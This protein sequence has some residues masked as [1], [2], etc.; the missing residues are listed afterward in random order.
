MKKDERKVSGNF[1][2]AGH[3][4]SFGSA[5]PFFMRVGFMC[6]DKEVPKTASV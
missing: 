5:P 6:N 1:G 3:G 2:W 4:D